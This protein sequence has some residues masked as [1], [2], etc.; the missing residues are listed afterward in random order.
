MPRS[1]AILCCLIVGACAEPGAGGE[2]TFAGEIAQ[3]VY[4]ACTPC[5]RPDGPTPFPLLGYDDVYRRRDKILEVTQERLMPPWLPTHGDFVGDRRLT[6]EQLALLDRWVA[7]G[8]PRGDASSEPPC[9]EFPAGWQLRTPDLVVTVPQVVTVPAAGPDVVRNLVVPVDV[10]AVKFV[11]AIEI[12]PGSPAVHHALLLVDAT[13]EARRLD[14]LDAEPGYPGMVDGNAKP[15]DGQFLPWTPG[16]RARPCADGMAWR[17]QPGHDLVL[18][19]H[20]APTGKPERV[21]PRIGLYFTNVPPSHVAFPLVLSSLQIDLPAGAA[22]CIVADHFVLPVPVTVQSLY[23]H[24]HHLCRRM[25]AT[26]TL[27]GE[28][29]RPLFAIDRW[30]FDWQDDYTFR[31]PVALPAGTRIAIEY[32]Y[33]NSDANPQNPSRPPRRVRYGQNSTDEM[34]S[35]T[36]QVTTADLAARRVL[37]EASL[38]HEISKAGGYDGPLLLQLATLL[39]DLQ[40][41]DEALR[42]IAEV[43]E[44]EP[45]RFEALF[46]LGAC[47]EAAG[48][49]AEAE[50]A[51]A[52]CLARDPRQ[53]A[54]RVQLGTVLLRSG[55]T[56]EAIEHYQQALQQMPRL[57][58]LHNNLATAGLASGQLDLAE[59]HYREAVA[60]DPDFFLAW[61]NLGRVLAATDRPADARRALLRAD[62]LQPGDAR[63][64][65]AL[66]RLGR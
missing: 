29:P 37:G 66:G 58:A 54:A 8:A 6:T 39:R 52:E 22:D 49:S 34:G 47:L 35:L 41:H 36:L 20:L 15:P 63:V 65:E 42:T 5:H 30:D 40:R 4:A 38:R 13:P 61:F 27:P 64:H 7:A 48:R 23:P 51:Y 57:A 60:I 11:A 21:Q 10:G 3:I 31:A 56:A 55:R 28:A 50:R 17:L 44:R 19:V 2:P 24:A 26:V 43:R 16:K 12:Q 14:A 33:D 18:Q 46:E 53:H 59:R 32:H 9:P 45:L 25:L 1:A 62:A